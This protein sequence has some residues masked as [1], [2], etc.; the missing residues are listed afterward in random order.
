MKNLALTILSLLFAFGLSAQDY[1]S[2]NYAK[3]TNKYMKYGNNKAET[4]QN[5]YEDCMSRKEF[6]N[7]KE[8]I[9]NKK[10]DN[11]MLATAKLVISTNQP[12]AFQIKQ[13]ME[14]FK[15]ENN[16]LELAKYAYEYCCNPNDYEEVNS[17]FQFKSN[18]KN[19][20]RHIH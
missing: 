11:K 12:T 18:I 20:E 8:Q 1:R 9:A 16:R 3:S 7:A 17:A 2:K 14:L 13:I 10:F 19:L 5:N 15:F 4:K 6:R